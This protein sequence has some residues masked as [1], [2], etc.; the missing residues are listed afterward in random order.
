MVVPN[1]A[2]KA[3]LDAGS[4]IYLSGASNSSL[5]R[6]FRCNMYT[7]VKMSMIPK[8]PHRLIFSSNK[9]TAIIA[10]NIGDERATG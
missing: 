3:Y 1:A 7:P 6:L 5:F 8:I 4:L 10:T 2:S 9:K